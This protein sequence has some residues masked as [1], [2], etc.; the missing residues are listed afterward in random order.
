MKKKSP[1]RYWTEEERKIMTD[2][3]AD[4]YTSDICRL[5]N[6]SYSSVSAQASI[7]GLKKSESFMEIE[8]C[9][10]AQRLRVVGVKSRYKKGRT[11]ENK[12]KPMPKEVYEK[13]KHTMFKPGRE[14]HNTHYDGHERTNQDGYIEVRIRKGKYVLKHRYVWEQANGKIP[15]GMIVVFKD[16]NPNNICLENLELISQVENLQRNTIHRFPP[17][18][19]R[20]IRLLGKLKRTINNEK[21]N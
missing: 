17:E 20:T 14:P 3:F 7:M 5:L 19:K 18:L 9:R 11:P 13:L 2:M 6:R 1:R 12:G 4:T 21:Q 16:R 10:Q 15:N 8:L